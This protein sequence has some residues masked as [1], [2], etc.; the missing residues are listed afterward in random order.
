MA[1]IIKII[2]TDGTEPSKQSVQGDKINAKVPRGKS[3]KSSLDEHR[4]EVDSIPLKL[5][6]R[7]SD[8]MDNGQ[9]GA[10]MEKMSGKDNAKLK[11]AATAGALTL[12]TMAV[13]EV[14]SNV[15]LFY[16]DTSKQNEMANISQGISMGTSVLTGVTAGLAVGGPVGAAIGAA[17]AI[18]KEAIGL[19]SQAFAL[20]RD[21]SNKFTQSERD[22]SRLGVIASRS[23]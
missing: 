4:Q 11:G 5:G 22:S 15:G 14:I 23:R 21:M 12:G 7:G 19:A 9:G 18:G 16:N 13:K 10:P 6:K 17:V 2:Y 3:V 20:S 8:S 1:S